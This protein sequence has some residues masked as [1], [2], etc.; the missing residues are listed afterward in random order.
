LR[1]LFRLQEEDLFRS[2]EEMLAEAYQRQED[3]I[4]HETAIVEDRANAWSAAG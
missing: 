4:A 3:R 2:R 1:Q